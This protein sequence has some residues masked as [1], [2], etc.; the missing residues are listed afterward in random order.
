[1]LLDF[2]QGNEI[3]SEN[4]NTGVRLAERKMDCLRTKAEDMDDQG[5]PAAFG[6][7]P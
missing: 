7:R 3:T 5:N 4:P 1:V 6:W 2:V